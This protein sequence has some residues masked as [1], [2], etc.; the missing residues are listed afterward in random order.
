MK[1]YVSILTICVLYACSP[2]KNLEI[3]NEFPNPYQFELIDTLEK[4]KDQLFSKATIWMATTFNSSNT[5]IQLKDKDA[6]KIIGKAKIQVN[7][8]L[9][10]IG[11]PLGYDY[12]D[13]TISIDVRDG[14]Y[15]CILSDFYHEGGLH[16]S[17]NTLEQSVSYG[18]LNNQ[19][20]PNE[21][22][23]NMQNRWAAIKTKVMHNSKLLLKDLE[24]FM[25]TEE[26]KF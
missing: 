14:R 8:P 6:G 7:G 21:M 24:K 18:S 15:R 22:G 23:F 16:K 26:D 4:T 5:V 1:F 13:Y 2:Y 3:S 9:N 12:V 19:T 11:Q 17:G 25:I 10:G 20:V